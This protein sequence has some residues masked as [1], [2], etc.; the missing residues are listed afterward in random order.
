MTTGTLSSSYHAL[1]CTIADSF[2]AG[3]LIGQ[4]DMPDFTADQ[5]RIIA[6]HDGV[7]LAVAIDDGAGSH[8]TNALSL[9]GDAFKAAFLDAIR[10]YAKAAV[11][12]NVQDELDD[13]ADTLALH[14][15]AEHGMRQE[16][17]A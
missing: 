16:D 4:G 12:P 3:T 13:R 10:P 2:D 14:L 7:L 6:E 8:I 1:I 5:L 17:F 11:T 15:P 9:N